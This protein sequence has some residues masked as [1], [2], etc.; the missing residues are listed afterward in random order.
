[1]LLRSP[2]RW[3]QVVTINLSPASHSIPEQSPIPRHLCG[4]TRGKS[5]L[6][7]ATALYRR[8]R[9]LDE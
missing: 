6:A 3:G 5:H 2:N 9:L 8:W 7:I 4:Q 1:M